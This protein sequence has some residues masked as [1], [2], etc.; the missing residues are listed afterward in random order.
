[1]ES[2]HVHEVSRRSLAEVLIVVVIVFCTFYTVS[3]VCPK[4][5]VPLDVA[6]RERA[7]LFAPTK[8]KK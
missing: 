8:K 3:T 1:M 4:A 2:Y 6:H 5:I 7:I